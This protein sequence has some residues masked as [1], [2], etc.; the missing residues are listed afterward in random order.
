MSAPLALANGAVNAA[1]KNSK[2]LVTY[3]ANGSA[4]P[5]VQNAVVANA[6]KASNNVGASVAVPG[7]SAAQVNKTVN[8]AAAAVV[9]ANA[10]A[11][12]KLRAKNSPLVR[13]MM[14]AEGKSRNAILAEVKAG[15]RKNLNGQF[16]GNV[17]KK[18]VS[19]GK[20]SKK[21]RRN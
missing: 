16:K 10:V 8:A 21:T 1:N 20:K 6:V 4:P 9:T 11:P 13:L 3:G 12:A 7:A 5:A 15:T 17:M 18:G 2:A 14:N 19:G